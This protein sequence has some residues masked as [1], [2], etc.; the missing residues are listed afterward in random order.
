M[1]IPFTLF[2]TFLLSLSLQAQEDNSLNILMEA[3]MPDLADSWTMQEYKLAATILVNRIE[4]GKLDLPHHSKGSARVIEKLFNPEGYFQYTD[5]SLTARFKASS[6][7]QLK[8][9]ELQKLYVKEFRLQNG[10]LN[11]GKEALLLTTSAL[12]VTEEISGLGAIFIRQNPDL[13]E[14]QKAGLARY[15]GGVKMVLLGSLMTLFDEVDYY[16]EED[17]CTF[18]NHF[19]SLYSSLERRLEPSDRQELKNKIIESKGKVKL[20]CIKQALG[21]T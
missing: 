9:S 13:N 5:T 1:K 20:D 8:I 16:P 4:E 17:V 12:Y 19:F 3:G 7:F 15:Q 18:A 11:Y 10:K 6:E 21:E 2:L 14:K